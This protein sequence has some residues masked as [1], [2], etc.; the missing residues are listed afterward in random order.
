MMHL[1]INSI[2]ANGDSLLSFLSTL[3]H[4]FD[5]IRL[6]EARLVDLQQTDAVFQNYTSNYSNRVNRRGYGAAIFL[7]TNIISEFM[8][9]LTV[10]LP[11]IE[12]VFR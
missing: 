6:T 1:N 4:K 2:R 3:N 5:N 7:L 12:A 8:N 11:H 9:S 10:I